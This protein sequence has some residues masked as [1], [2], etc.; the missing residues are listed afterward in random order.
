MVMTNYDDRVWRVR[1]I[2][3]CRT[4]PYRDWPNVIQRCNHPANKNPDCGDEDVECTLDNC[5]VVHSSP[6]I[7]AMRET[8]G[9]SRSDVWYDAMYI[10]ADSG[11]YWAVCRI[12]GDGDVEE[13][14]KCP[15][16]ERA[17]RVAWLLGR[18]AERCRQMQ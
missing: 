2:L 15:D 5:P 13:Y 6:L 11:G 3:D 1:V 10:D 12:D 7:A 9:V 17:E 4:C 8:P 18:E 16:R 14:A